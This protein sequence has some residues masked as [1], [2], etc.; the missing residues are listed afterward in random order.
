[1]RGVALPDGPAP[2]FAVVVDIPL[3]DAIASRVRDETGIRLGRA[4]VVLTGRDDVQPAEG[5]P[6]V[7]ALPAAR[8]LSATDLFSWVTLIE[9]TDWKTGRTAPVTWAI[10]LNISRVYDRLSST[11]ARIGNRS[12]GQILLLLL[13]IVAVLFL[14]IEFFALIMGFALAK[15]ITGSVHELF[16]GTDR[17]QRGE[18]DRPIKVEARDQLGELADQFNAMTSSI[19]NLMV[20]Q[21]EK[22]RLE[23][24][25]KVARKIQLSLLPQGRFEMPGIRITAICEPAREVGGDYYDLFPLGDGVL[26]VLIADVSGKGAS[27]ALYMAELKGL[28]LALSE[29]HHSPRELLIQANR[30]IADNLDTKSFITMTYAVI[31]LPTATMTYARAGHTPLIH[32]PAGESRRAQILAPD[33]L[34]VGLKIDHGERFEQLLEEVRIPLTPGDLFVFFTDGISEAMNPASDCFEESRLSQIVEEHGHLP[35]DEL[36]ERIL[37]EITTFAAGEP[38]HDDRTLILLKIEALPLERD[39]NALAIEQVM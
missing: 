22:E 36:R 19:Q 2:P 29:S 39:L 20:Q 38:Q 34:V 27:A 30:I 37:R 11:Q 32:L 6:E 35:T 26:G 23:E 5:R 17:V 21:A 4:S 31:D 24:E 28:M 3:N 7:A 18:F 8:A 16:V 25:L 13:A 10:D 15:S 12:F 9:Y 14:V 1:M 33:G